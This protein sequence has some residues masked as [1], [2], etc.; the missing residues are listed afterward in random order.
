M[1][2][3]L[4][5]I[6]GL[7]FRKKRRG[8]SPPGGQPEI[9]D[10]TPHGAGSQIGSA[11]EGSGGAWYQAFNLSK[12][13]V[14]ASRVKW[15]GTSEDRRKG[16]LG[17]SSIDAGEGIYI[18]PTQMVHMFGM[19]FSI[20]IAFLGSDGRVLFMHH[21]LKPNRLSRLVWQA[22][23]ALELAPGSLR[24]GGTVIGDIIEFREI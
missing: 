9:R 4:Q 22:E 1:R 18:V 20:D 15:A 23:G 19:Q 16:L 3:C 21:G 11:R 13:R 2:R 8:D 24:A 7:I 10:R 6:A 14:I 5:R 17:R 12:N